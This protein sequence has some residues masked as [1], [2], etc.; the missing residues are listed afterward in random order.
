MSIYFLVYYIMSRKNRLEYLSYIE[1]T[2][3][4]RSKLIEVVVSSVDEAVENSISNNIPYTVLEGSKIVK[5]FP[6]SGKRELV[7]ELSTD[8]S[9]AKLGRVELA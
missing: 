2:K 3:K 4:H 1:D 6:S 5:V 9:K 8:I 7:G